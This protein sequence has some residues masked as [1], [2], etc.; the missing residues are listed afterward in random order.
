MINSNHFYQSAF[1]LSNKNFIK[2]MIVIVPKMLLVS[3]PNQYL[4]HLGIG[5]TP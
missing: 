5:I 1:T 4:G 2:C 3:R